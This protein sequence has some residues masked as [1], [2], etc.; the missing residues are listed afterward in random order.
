MKYKLI[1]IRRLQRLCEL[2]MSAN[3]GHKSDYVV[4]LITNLVGRE[5]NT[6]VLKDASIGH[7]M[8]QVSITQCTSGHRNVA[9][10][11]HNVA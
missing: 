8:H 3:L 9:W 4:F 10:Y 7:S 2:L 5:L 6:C 11:T 1:C